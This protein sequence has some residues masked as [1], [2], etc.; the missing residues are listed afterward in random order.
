MHAG[1]YVAPEWMLEQHPALFNEL[2][3]VRQRG[4]FADGGFTS[5]VMLNPASYQPIVV[6]VDQGSNDKTVKA[7]E[8]L[9]TTLKTLKDELEA[10]KTNTQPDRWEVAS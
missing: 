8:K 4:S 2:E 10:I 5:P 3:T 9:E 1:E 7:I 6:A